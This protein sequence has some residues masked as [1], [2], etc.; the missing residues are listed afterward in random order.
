M[1][2][3]AFT[4]GQPWPDAAGSHIQAHGGGPGRIVYDLARSYTRITGLGGNE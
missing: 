1:K 4:P 2:A 3:N